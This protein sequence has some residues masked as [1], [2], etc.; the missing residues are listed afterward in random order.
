M[1]VCVRECVRMRGR[2]TEGMG[3]WSASKSCHLV[4][5]GV[6]RVVIMV[7]EACWTKPE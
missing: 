3:C 2:A 7:P 5:T 6:G 4:K 1:R